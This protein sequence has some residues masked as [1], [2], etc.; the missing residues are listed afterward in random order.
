MWNKK[1]ILSIN[2]HK[3]QGMFYSLLIKYH[4][5]AHKISEVTSTGKENINLVQNY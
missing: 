1:K 2:I 3:K 5:L 4:I